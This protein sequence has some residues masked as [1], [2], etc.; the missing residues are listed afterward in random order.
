MTSEQP[1]WLEGPNGRL[2]AVVHE[3]DKPLA[4]KTCLIMLTAGQISLAGPQR[5]YWKAARALQARGIRVLRLDLAGIGDS[6]PDNDVI[7]FDNHSAREVDVA[8]AYARE[9]LGAGRI[10]L[11]GLCS[12][13]RVAFKCAATN[14]AVDAVLAW[15]CPIYSAG[16]L[17]P[18]S[19]EERLSESRVKH[20]VL[21]LLRALASFEFRRARWWR[22]GFRNALS[23]LRKLGLGRGRS[24]EPGAVGRRFLESA[25]HYLQAGREA[26]FVYGG[27]DKVAL[28]EFEKRFGGV[29]QNPYGAQGYCVVA[30][31]THT[32]ASLAAQRELIDI[33]TRWL[34]SPHR[35]PVALQI[36]PAVGDTAAS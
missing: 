27:R 15:G 26:L 23:Q 16:D 9:V 29:A 19:P 20:K 30:D 12:G 36:R 4:S 11:Q 8:V 24:E 35:A 22:K 21:K 10:V 1:I 5:L 2:F 17:M 13:A 28:S 34:L 6:V 3:P 14:D 32:F 31:G 33:T 18:H 7:H 25:D